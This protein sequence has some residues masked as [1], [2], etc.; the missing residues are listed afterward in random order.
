LSAPEFARLT[1]ALRASKVG[2]EVRR[3]GLERCGLNDPAAVAALLYVVPNVE[4]VLLG[5]NALGGEEQQQREEVGA[6]RSGETL[7]PLPAALARRLELRTLDL[8]RNNLGDAAGEVICDAMTT[9]EALKLDRLLLR[10]NRLGSLTAEAV[11][12]LIAEPEAH[13]RELDLGHNEILD[14]GVIALAAALGLA[15]SLAL[16]NLDCNS[17]SAV[18]ARAL[19]AAMAEAKT[20]RKLSVVDNDLGDVGTAAL[21]AAIEGSSLEEVHMRGNH[22][23]QAGTSI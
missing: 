14:S 10:D 1:E 6:G 5:R 16:L 20:L 15:G 13:L 2:A 3:V 4:E 22:S 7:G 19:A 18:G 8:G 23:I 12:R 17:I 9:G 11:G 21:E